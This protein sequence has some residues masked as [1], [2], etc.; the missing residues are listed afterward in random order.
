MKWID[1]FTFVMRSSITAL[2]EKVEDPERMLHQLICDMEEELAAVRTSVAETLADEIQLA[3]Q[4]EQAREQADLWA[5]RAETAFRRGD[6]AASRSALEQKLRGEERVAAWQETYELQRVQTAE[7][8]SAYR[9]LEDKTRQA[10]HKRT[11]LVARLSRAESASKIN[12]ALDRA[13]GTSAF[14]EF[15]RLERK[16]ER[17]EAM[18]DAYDRL[19]GRDPDAE[20]LAARFAAEERR[21]RLEAEFAALRNRVTDV[22][23]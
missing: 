12:Q 6:E 19:E 8:Q 10:R 18:S 1:S 23:S 4:V 11:L 16:V 7:L 15:S 17:A 21:E 20:A 13:E 5:G 2:R 9:D 22:V 3:R 14:A